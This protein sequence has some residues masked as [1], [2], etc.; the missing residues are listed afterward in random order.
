MYHWITRCGA[1]H[2]FLYSTSA[3]AAEVAV[4]IYLLQ[5]VLKS[6]I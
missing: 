5:S 4:T 3:L 2:V 6:V 1:V